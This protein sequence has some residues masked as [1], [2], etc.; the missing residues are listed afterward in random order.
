LTS[1]VDFP[2]FRGRIFTSLR[3]RNS[4]SIRGHFLFENLP[5]FLPVS[6]HQFI[7][8][9]LRSVV[10]TGS[11]SIVDGAPAITSHKPLIG[12]IGLIGLGARHNCGD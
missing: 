3:S 1:S 9:F 4:R 10:L 6:V 2:G 7:R 11:G 5:R 12:V 8:I